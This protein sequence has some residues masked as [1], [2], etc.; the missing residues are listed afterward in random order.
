MFKNHY[1]G[2]V[3]DYYSPGESNFGLRILLKMIT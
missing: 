1:K 2:D 3:S